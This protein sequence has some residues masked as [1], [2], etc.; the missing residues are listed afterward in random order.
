MSIQKTAVKD[1]FTVRQKASFALF[2]FVGW[3]TSTQ[4]FLFVVVVVVV[5]F[6]LASGKK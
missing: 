1:Y 5:V 4:F 3:I 2:C 6:Y